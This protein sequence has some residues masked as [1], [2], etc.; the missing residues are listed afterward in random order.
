[1]KTGIIKRMRLFSLEKEDIFLNIEIFYYTIFN[2]IIKITSDS[3]CRF[4][5]MFHFLPT[6]CISQKNNCFLPCFLIN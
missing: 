6:P 4:D 1:M 2:Y 5:K 3:N